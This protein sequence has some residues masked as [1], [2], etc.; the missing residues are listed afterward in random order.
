[1]LK[2][3]AI[4]TGRTKIT[5]NWVVGRGSGLKRLANTLFDKEF[6]DWL[7]IYCWVIEHPAG[8]IVIDTGIPANANKPIWFPPFMRLV[9]RAAKFDISTGQELGPQMRTRGLSPEDV[10]WVIHT[11]LH[12][13]HEG[14]M[15]YFPNAEFLISRTEW[16]SAT[17]LKGRMGGY[18]NQRWPKW[19]EPNL[20][21]FQP[22]DT[23]AGRYT[24]P[25]A[26]GVHLV[27]TPG[28]SPGHLSVIVEEGDHDL[29]FAG[30]VSY[31]QDLLLQGVLDGI[32]ADLE[33]LSDTH[34][35]VQRYLAENR[36]VY[37]PSH[38]PDSAARLKARSI[39]GEH[40]HSTAERSAS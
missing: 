17:G 36:A 30:D 25:G 39:V 3:H 12:Q 32:S 34:R 2:V 15:H 18:L 1:M 37:L 22:D 9:Q 6:T 35:R 24:I 33:T 19:L 38:D 7:P 10:R 26:D 28:H 8:L 29:F 11:H 40:L 31:T 4:S 13:D 27:S 21:D 5:R 23:F 20:I 14:G 16:E